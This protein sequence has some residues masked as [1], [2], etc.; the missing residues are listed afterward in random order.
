MHVIRTRR[1]RRWPGVGLLAVAAALIAALAM[2]ASPA[3]AA[4]QTQDYIG[5]QPGTPDIDRDDLAFFLPDGSQAMGGA[6]GTINLSLD[7]RPVVAYCVETNA[8]LRES[9]TVVS[10]VTET[11]LA[12]PED[13]AVLWILRN[14]TPT[15]APTPEKAQQAA[16]SQVAVW[17]LRGQLRAV[18]PT[19]DATLNASVAAL[20]QT[21]LTESATPRTLALAAGTPA[22]GARTATIT[23]SGKPGAVV[24]LSIASGPGTLSAPSVTIGAGGTATVTLTAPGAGTTVVSATTDSDGTLYR[25]TPTDDSQATATAAAGQLSATVSVTFTATQ[26]G[27]PSGQP[28]GPVARLGLTKTAPARARVLTRVRYVITVR[29]RGKAVARGVVVRD[30]IPN[31]LSFVRSSRKGT[32]RN[33]TISYTVGDL[34]PGQARK[35]TV[36]LL[37]DA[38]VRGRRTNVAT[39]S[40]SQVRSVTARAA[41]VFRPLARRV[42]PAV[43]G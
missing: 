16:A 12:T 9:G 21:A 40:A 1:R 41:T 20:I 2:F 17:V 34:R 27:G 28:S 13:R 25:I 22:A 5:D 42:Q 31:G 29:N 35:I 10:D 33:G 7:G 24:A 8:F 38:D 43:T 37:A 32:L 36:W 11:P 15:G 3:F 19:D 18:N 30:R 14:A 4:P 23:V 39:A 26:T 6:A